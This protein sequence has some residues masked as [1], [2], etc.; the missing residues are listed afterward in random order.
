MTTGHMDTVQ[1]VVLGVVQGATE[2]LPIS[3]SAHL[4]VLPK[5]FGWANPGL[6]FTVWLHWGT[7]LAVL[8]Y[9]G[10]DVLRRRESEPFPKGFPWLVGLATLPGA[11][12]GYLLAD[13]VET[14]FWTPGIIA[15]AMILMGLVLSWGDRQRADRRALGTLT[16]GD[17]LLIGCAQALAL[18]PGVSRSGATISVALFLGL[19]RP[20]AARLS[21][22]LS[23]PIIFG[24]GVLELPKLVQGS[25]VGVIFHQGGG[26]FWQ[27]PMVLGFLASFITGF[28]SIHFLLKYVQRH[29]YTPFVIYRLLFGVGLFSAAVFHR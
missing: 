9:C 17:S 25:S 10:R 26:T 28:V 8:I 14:L 6:A 22:W 2:F 3:S 23:L 24:A 7:L 13:Q 5:L 15:T 29:R 1:A 4:I 18:I 21:F 20:E 11:V 19:A 27:S 12:A 16:W